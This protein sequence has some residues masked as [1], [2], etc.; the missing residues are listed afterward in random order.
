MTAREAILALLSERK[1]GQTICPSEAARL[2]AE[3]DEA[4]RAKMPKVHRAVDAM[5]ADG[6]IVL[7]WKGDRKERRLGAYRIRA[8]SPS[9]SQ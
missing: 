1:A 7:T 9:R 6:V 4:W 2:L 8:A 3:T 5:L